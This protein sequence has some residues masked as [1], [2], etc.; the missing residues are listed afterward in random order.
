M[1]EPHNENKLTY[2]KTKTKLDSRFFAAAFLNGASASKVR[3]STH[4]DGSAFIFP[5][6]YGP[7]GA[8][9]FE[10]RSFAYFSKIPDDVQ[11][12]LR[13]G[14]GLLVIDYSNEGG[15]AK[16]T[17]LRALH[18]RL[19]EMEISPR[20]VMF[21]TQNSLFKNNYED[22]R[23][24]ANAGGVEPINIELYHCFLR[25]MSTYVL[26]DI[27]PSGEFDKR[28][29]SYLKSIKN[30]ELRPKHFL[31]LNFTPRAH[32]IAT[33]LY[34]MLHGLE[35][36]GLISFPGLANRKMNI[37]GRVRDL[38]ARVPF[39]QLGE[40]MALV[41][42]LEKAPPRKLDTDPFSR[43]SPVIDIG[44]WW[45]YR[46]SWFSLV[47]ESGVNGRGHRRFTEKPFKAVMGLHPFLIIGLPGTLDEMK[48]YGFRS[49]SPHL[50]EAYDVVSDDQQRMEL[51]LA[52][53]R[54]LCALSDDDWRVLARQ[55]SEAVLH[56]YD[57][58]GGPLEDYFVSGVEQ[59]LLNKM[60][61]LAQPREK[62]E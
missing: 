38:M 13:E 47:T 2:L 17:V 27:I 56:N 1:N 44:E 6:I 3:L 21:L 8:L 42:Q 46:D 10:D 16:P 20:R 29:K 30:N 45:Y 18:A 33:M 49:F 22:W 32:R 35:E 36:K 61:S 25:E 15:E 19:A 28:K 23:L 34:I 50:N 41:D 5:I 62:A 11:T 24:S 55:L 37:E 43:I 57:Q 40:M 39:P 60:R 53:F 12:A 58:F 26:Q 54:R 31:S 9:G 48:G 4:D 14:R 52:E 59:S 7:S 51:V